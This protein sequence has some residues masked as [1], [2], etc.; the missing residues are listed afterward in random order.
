MTWIKAGEQLLMVINNTVFFFLRLSRVPLQ[1]WK[2]FKYEILVFNWYWEYCVELF[3]LNSF[4]QYMY[5]L[6]RYRDCILQK[7]IYI[8]IIAVV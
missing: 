4:A 1:P 6:Y 8:V 3:E 2:T 5:I 7:I